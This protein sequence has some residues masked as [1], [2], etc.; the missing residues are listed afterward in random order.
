[1]A[2]TFS[3]IV[4]MC[5]AARSNYKVKWQC[6]QINTANRTSSIFTSL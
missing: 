3:K 5:E 2:Q 6:K 4:P 1:M